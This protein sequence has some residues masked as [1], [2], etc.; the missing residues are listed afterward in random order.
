MDL[1]SKYILAFEWTAQEIERARARLVEAESRGQTEL[2][3]TL[4]V[5]LNQLLT[6]R[7]KLIKWLTRHT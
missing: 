4:V 3:D 7:T 1:V 2:R 5:R 6:N